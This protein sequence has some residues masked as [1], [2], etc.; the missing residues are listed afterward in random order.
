MKRKLILQEG[1]K[2]WFTSDTH[3]AH[4]NIVRGETRW[5]IVE[6]ARDFPSAQSM[7]CTIIDNL[8]SQVSEHDVLF[9]LGDFAFKSEEKAIELLDSLACKNV[10]LLLGNHDHRIESSETLRKMFVTVDEYL[11]L[12]VQF[13]NGSTKDYV[14]M[15]YPLM[16]WK[17]KA[18][19]TFHL[20]GHTHLPREKR[21]GLGRMMDVGMDGSGMFAIEANEI[22]DLLN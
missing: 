11:E 20:H 4:T 16:S 19:G 21:I 1:Q 17:G 13:P 6:Q 18:V 2:L 3:Y 5:P 8:N 9:H 12:H 14:L 10:H 15:H 7:N 22:N